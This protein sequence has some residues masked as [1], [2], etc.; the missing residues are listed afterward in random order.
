MI[1]VL[2]L[3]CTCEVFSFMEVSHQTDRSVLGEAGGGPGPQTRGVAKV[4]VERDA[5]NS[6]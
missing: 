3:M 5:R 1:F 2:R 6:E 4:Q